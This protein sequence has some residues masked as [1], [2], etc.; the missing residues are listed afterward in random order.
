MLG[1]VER[2][3]EHVQREL[4]AQQRL[5]QHV[6]ERL[7]GEALLGQLHRQ[8]VQH[9]VVRHPL[10]LEGDDLLANRHHPEVQ[11]DRPQH[12]LVADLLD[13]GLGLLLG[14]RVPVAGELADQRLAPPQV[15]LLDL[16]ALPQVQVDGAGVDRGVRPLGLHGADHL[17]AAVLHDRERVDRG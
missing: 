16:V 11:L 17:A 2:S 1:R 14:L 9:L 15:E 7:G 3:L 5:G 13:V 4:L 8:Q 10:L 12:P 6:P